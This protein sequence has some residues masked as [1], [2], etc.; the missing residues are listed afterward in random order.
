[1]GYKKRQHS[2]YVAG[3]QPVKQAE[4][5][6]HTCVTARCVTHS[7]TGGSL[8]ATRASAHSSSID[9]CDKSSTQAGKR[10]T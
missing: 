6:L 4:S 7:S 1:M 3:V 10:N 2:T 8:C 5:L 9:S